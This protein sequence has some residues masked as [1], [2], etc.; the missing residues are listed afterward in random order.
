MKT[1][2]M[3]YFLVVGLTLFLVRS[4]VL[5]HRKDVAKKTAARNEAAGEA[6]AQAVYD[7]VERLVCKHESA[8]LVQRRKLVTRDQYGVECRERWRQE[9]KYFYEN[10]IEPALDDEINSKNIAEAKV[11]T[12]LSFDEDIRTFL[13]DKYG[14]GAF[15]HSFYT[16]IESLINNRV[17]NLFEIMSDTEPEDVASLSPSEFESYCEGLLEEAGWNAQMVAGSGDQG[18]DIVARKDGVTAVFQCKLYS[19]P[20]GNKPVQEIYTGRTFYDAEIAAVVTNADFTPGARAAAEQTGV[21]LLHYSELASFGD[22][23]K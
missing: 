4:L 14:Q 22:E 23:S 12:Y 11:H 16:Y 1:A 13:L 7:V 21:L 3:V 20:L 19:S 2:C 6:A 15:V 17:E 8:L 10:I 18:V 5:R 9:L